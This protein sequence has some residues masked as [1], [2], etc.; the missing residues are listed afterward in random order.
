MQL[1]RLKLGA[2]AQQLLTFYCERQW[3]IQLDACNTFVTRWS[4]LLE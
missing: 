3:G 1:T 2:E 4:A